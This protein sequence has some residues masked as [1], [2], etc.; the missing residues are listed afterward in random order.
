LRVQRA[1]AA[2]LLA[3]ALS[4]CL[5]SPL[6]AQAPWI[7]RVL[8]MIR[9]APAAETIEEKTEGAD[10]DGPPS[11]VLADNG[12]L[13][14]RLDQV[15]QQIEGKHY[16]EAV[17]QL[18][19]WL[20]DAEI[21]DFFLNRDDER[22]GGRSFQ[23]EIRRLLSELPPEGKTAYRVQ[24]EP[25]ARGRL[26]AAVARNDESQ[27][28]DVA[29]RFPE[30]QAG[31]E[32][33]YRLG[34]WLWD[35]GRPGAAAVCLERLA[36]R[37]EA[38][39][40][41]EPALTR[42]IDECRKR[43]AASSSTTA[44]DWPTYRGNPARNRRV[45]ARAPFLAPRWTNP[46][47]GDAHTQLA[48]ERAWQAYREGTATSLPML[49]S[50]AVGDLIFTRTACGVAAFDLETGR[51]RWRH[52]SD[53]DGDNTGLD[54][55]VWQ[56]P[57]GGALSA[58]DECVYVLEEM[59][60]AQADSGLPGQSLL[61]AREHFKSREGNL[62][63]RV[64]G[65]DG[66][67]EPRLAGALFLGPPLCWHDRLYVLVELNRVLSLA[68]LDRATGQRDW[69]Q[70]L[71]QIE[72][73][74]S[75]DPLRLVAGAMPSISSEEIIVCPTSGGT[76]VALDLP[77]QS[78]LWAYRYARKAPGPA[79][80]SELLE[81]GPRLD[82]FDRWLDATVAIGDGCVVVAPPESREI[83]CLDLRTG[84]PRWTKPR[85][86]G[87]FVG[88]L[89]AEHAVIVGRRQVT[90]LR[91]VDGAAAWKSAYRNK[92]LPAGRGVL[93]GERYF[94]PL[95]SATIVEIDLATGTLAAEHKSPRELT[96][97]NLIWHKG[98][99][100]SH[101][102]FA[103]EAY[104]EQAW[105]IAHLREQLARDPRDTEALVRRG[106]LELSSGRIPEAIADFRAAHEAAPSAKTRSRL[107]SALLE[108]VRL[109][110]PASEK[111]AAE[112]DALIGP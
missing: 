109:K 41:F 28:R 3:V 67:A 56:E 97:G 7:R 12:D 13:R 2:A 72:G 16:T 29:L 36:A 52:P 101:S 65:P 26:A 24:F 82:Q 17:G 53:D 42:L 10:A 31:D 78:L 44:E 43:S 48:I 19:R 59:R 73:A 6:P 89:T 21:R 100:V 68:V 18:G 14:R 46:V 33:W 49:S 83:H 4:A 30:L 110:L 104:D 105:L 23:A 64:G 69:T 106:E 9:P 76:V 11:I 60:V 94:L 15:R 84:Q 32:A 8:N 34:H 37:S 61:S 85:G 66:G 95:T 74:A 87:M 40:I 5:A 38:A 63:W 35:H 96:A 54:R 70:E 75:D 25:I 88:C 99:F 62:R 51:C 58:D 47:C 108:A 111:Y 39:A 92:A 57:G 71:A 50:L 93:A 55:I 98:L 112:L 1:V 91:L 77:T 22:R 107:V 90:A 20:Q 86:E 79:A 80:E 27:L 103:I 102:P 45:A 81:S